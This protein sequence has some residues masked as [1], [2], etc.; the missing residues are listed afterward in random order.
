MKAAF[1]EEDIYEAKLFLSL[2]E[3]A[4]G[5]LAASEVLKPEG[6]FREELA[7]QKLASE[8][9]GTFG[10][11]GFVAMS[12]YRF[13]SVESYED[14]TY[15]YNSFRESIDEELQLD[16][17][18]NLPPE[19]QAHLPVVQG[20]MGIAKVQAENLLVSAFDY[21]NNK[22]FEGGWEK[23][24]ERAMTLRAEVDAYVDKVATQDAARAAAAEKGE[25]YE[26]EVALQP[27]DEWWTNFIDLH[28]DFWDPPLPV[29][30][31][32]PPANSLRDKGR[33]DG[34]PTT[35]NDLKGAL[36]ESPY[37]HFLWNSNAVDAIF[38]DVPQGSVGGPFRAPKGYLISY[39]KRKLPASKSI[40]IRDEANLKALQEDF[41]QLSFTR[42]CHEALNEA[43]VTGL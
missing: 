29:T 31:K 4:K 17:N 11:F 14:Y 8:N 7:A 9:A 20:I 16:E 41:A 23:A 37:T 26:P 36:G 15:L 6:P 19:L 3:A 5:K 10:S 30:G 12:A 33:F 39:V 34:T 21:P 43:Q 24:G 32:A 42:F 27:F 25:T 35:R 22:W 1:D 28:S 13:P 40:S 2:M 18:G 38:F